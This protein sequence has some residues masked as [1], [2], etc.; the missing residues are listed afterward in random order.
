V[1]AAKRHRVDRCLPVSPEDDEPAITRP[2]IEERVLVERDEWLLLVT[3]K[4]LL[5]DGSDT[6]ASRR[7]RQRALVWRPGWVFV[8]GRVTGQPRKDPAPEIHVPEVTVLLII[9]LYDRC[10]ATMRRQDHL[11]IRAWLAE[12]ARTAAAPIE[13]V[14]TA[15]D[16]PD[17]QESRDDT[18]QHR[19]AREHPPAT[20]PL[21]AHP[22]NSMQR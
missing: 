18:H 1:I 15:F 10:T 9:E 8:I 14:T 7:E 17:V 4:I 20:A 2:L 19:T 22:K 5:E 11:V 16:L 21:G 13:A 3:D 6:R 12:R